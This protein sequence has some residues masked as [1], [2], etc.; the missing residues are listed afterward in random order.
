MSRLQGK[1][2][3]AWPPSLRVSYQP[4]SHTANTKPSTTAMDSR[5][6]LTLR[7]ISPIGKRLFSEVE[8]LDPRSP[9]SCF[10][11]RWTTAAYYNYVSLEQCV[12]CFSFQFSSVWITILTLNPMCYTVWFGTR[13]IRKFILGVGPFHTVGCGGDCACK[14][15]VNHV[16]GKHLSACDVSLVFS[17]CC[18]CCYLLWYALLVL[19][20]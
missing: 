14:L 2:R 11:T 16:W 12:S 5:P 20:K 4:C 17:V 13:R 7:T 15:T 18:S 10:P 1:G 3:A 6:F 9:S 19:V 8:A